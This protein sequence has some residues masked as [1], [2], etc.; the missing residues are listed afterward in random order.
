MRFF[1]L[2]FALAVPFWLLGALVDRRLAVGMTLPV[3]SLQ[4]VSPLIAAL[5]L[6]HHEEGRPGVGRLLRRLVDLR[7]IRLKWLPVVLV[8]VPAIYV[9]S[10][11]AMRLLGRPLPEPRISWM[12]VPVLLAAYFV[13]A[14]GEEGGW[15]GYALDPMQRRWNAVGA[16]VV[17]GLLW[18]LLHVVPDLQARRDAAWIVWQRG[19]YD[20]GLRVLI[21]WIY[22]ITAGTRSHNTA[23]TTENSVLATILVHDTDNVSASLF[24]N[25][26]SHYDP[27]FTGVMT[28]VTAVVVVLLWRAE[29][30]E[31]LWFRAQ[32]RLSR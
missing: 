29:E 23:R 15:S 10:Y 20:V 25:D 16:G 7:S 24:P 1:L 9:L 28:A 31:P 26:G 12:T 14:V 30:P 5:V 18:G 19:I 3:S 8:L 21:V 32:G 17:L 2:V 22:N 4:F 27:A 6:I 13:A 11:V